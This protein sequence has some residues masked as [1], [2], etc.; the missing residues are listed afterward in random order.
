MELIAWGECDVTWDDVF[1]SADL[2]RPFDANAALTRKPIANEDT[3]A[4]VDFDSPAAYR[5]EGGAKLTAEG[6]GRFG[7]GL[8]LERTLASSAVVPLWLSRMPDEGTLEFWFAPDEVPEHIHCYSLLMAG[9]LDLMKL[10]AD[11]S[12]ALRLSWRASAGLYDPQ[13]SIAASAAQSRDWFRPGQWQHVAWQWDRQAVRYYV[14]GVLVDYSTNQPLPFF[15]TPSSIKLGS[16]HSVYAWSGLI[17]E[18]RMSRVE[19]VWTAGSGGR[20]VA[21][22][23]ACPAAN[24]GGEAGDARQ[25]AAAQLYGRT[26]EAAGQAPRSARRRGDVGRLEVAAAAGRRRRLQAP[27]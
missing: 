24:G 9:D 14:D 22:V 1:F 2:P 23:R 19:R 12:S 3:I 15:Q 27:A 13:P 11:T 16:Q 7:R 25:A 10:Q 20:Q 8:R 6:G 21:R 18:V 4:L 17:D 5:L 26:S